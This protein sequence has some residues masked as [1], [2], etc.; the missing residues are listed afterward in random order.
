MSVFLRYRL[1]AETKR[2][3]GSS[4]VNIPLARLAWLECR[5]Y[6]LAYE[7]LTFNAAPAKWSPLF[8]KRPY[9]YCG[10]TTLP[11]ACAGSTGL[12]CQFEQWRSYRR[13]PGMDWKSL[14]CVSF[15]PHF[16]D[17]SVCA[18]DQFAIFTIPHY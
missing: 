6:N 16:A 9:S 15:V 1:S 17:S 2:L 8:N 12:W 10:H 5:A 3:G 14:A 13:L 7:E 4:H 18:D 11:G